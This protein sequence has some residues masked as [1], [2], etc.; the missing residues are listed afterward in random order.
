MELLSVAKKMF[1]L[2]LKEEKKKELLYVF[3][4]NVLLGG[5]SVI[6]SYLTATEGN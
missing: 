5:V 3:P 4:S 2:K 1:P 6:Q